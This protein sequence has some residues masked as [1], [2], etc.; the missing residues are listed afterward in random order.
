MSGLRLPSSVSMVG[1]TQAPSADSASSVA[2]SEWS[3]SVSQL[4]RGE[5]QYN[6]RSVRDGKTL[7]VGRPC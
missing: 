2:L 5:G 6:E 1:W 4:L 7:N 3:L